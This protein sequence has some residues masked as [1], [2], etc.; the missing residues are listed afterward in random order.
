MFIGHAGMHPSYLAHKLIPQVRIWPHLFGEWILIQAL[1][2]NFSVLSKMFS[3]LTQPKQR[4]WCLSAWICTEVRMVTFFVLERLIT[5][6]AYWSCCT[7]VRDASHCLN[8]SFF[9]S[10]KTVCYII[11]FIYMN[12]WAASTPCPSKHKK[13]PWHLRDVPA[14]HSRSTCV[15]R[16]LLSLCSCSSRVWRSCFWSASELSWSSSSRCGDTVLTFSLV[17]VEKIINSTVVPQPNLELK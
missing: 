7:I 8:M 14:R 3:C 13:N 12:K 11:W 6:C 1:L 16:S 15:S 4:L 2:Q 10:L 5:P 17:W 9:L